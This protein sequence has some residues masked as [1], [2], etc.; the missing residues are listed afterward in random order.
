MVRSCSR[1]ASLRRLLA[2]VPGEIVGYNEREL[3]SH[4]LLTARETPFVDAPGEVVEVVSTFCGEYPLSM[5]KRR[6]RDPRTQDL[7]LRLGS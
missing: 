4:R 7:R 1:N 5:L 3:V 6:L 2:F